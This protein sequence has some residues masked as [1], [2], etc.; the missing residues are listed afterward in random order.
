MVLKK[1]EMLKK[2][3]NNIA[4]VTN[5]QNKKTKKKVRKL[6][7]KTMVKDRCHLPEKSTT[8]FAMFTV[9]I[10]VSLCSSD[11]HPSVICH[12]LNVKYGQESDDL[13]VFSTGN[14]SS[15]FYGE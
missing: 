5:T 12:T 14:V 8:V 3:T 11:N 6:F 7:Y 1:V 2:P 13:A 4:D 9:I 10:V 15:S